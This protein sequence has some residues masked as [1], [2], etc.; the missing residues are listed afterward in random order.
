MQILNRTLKLTG[1]ETSDV[2]IGVNIDQGVVIVL[3]NRGPSSVDI[4]DIGP[5]GANRF[6]II[7]SMKIIKLRSQGQFTSVDVTAF[8]C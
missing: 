6:V 4:V 2:V 1:G 8:T 5:L 7:G 3:E